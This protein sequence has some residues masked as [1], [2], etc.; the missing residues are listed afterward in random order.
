MIT[1]V[2]LDQKKVNVCDSQKVSVKLLCAFYQ[3]ISSFLFYKSFLFLFLLFI[4]KIAIDR[5]TFRVN[6]VVGRLVQFQDQKRSRYDI[7]HHTKQILYPTNDTLLAESPL[8]KKSQTRYHVFAH[9]KKEEE[10][11]KLCIS[12]MIVI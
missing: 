8:R 10:E 4:T 6:L 2:F 3:E 1:D 12:A 5:L 11:R 7:T 9:K